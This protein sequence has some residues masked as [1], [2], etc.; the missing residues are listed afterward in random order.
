V[1]DG[2]VGRLFWGVERMKKGR[3]ARWRNP[4]FAFGARNARFA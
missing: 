4:A 1:T 3:I 2:L